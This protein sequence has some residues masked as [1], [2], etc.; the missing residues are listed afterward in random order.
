MTE[1]NCCDNGCTCGNLQC[2]VT[3][4]DTGVCV[5]LNAETAA[6]ATKV[7]QAVRAF[8][9]LCGEPGCC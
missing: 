4:T 8:S 7:K 9:A 5:E 1:T 2:R 6:E 3:E